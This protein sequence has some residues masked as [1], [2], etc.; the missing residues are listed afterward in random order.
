MEAEGD[1]G[2][3]GGG[4]PDVLEVPQSV[5]ALEFR[6]LARQKEPAGLLGEIGK[7]RVGGSHVLGAGGVVVLVK[8]FVDVHKGHLHRRR[9]KSCCFDIIIQTT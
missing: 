2:G 6:A 3:E 4:A 8:P 1:A 9:L 5:R 7:L